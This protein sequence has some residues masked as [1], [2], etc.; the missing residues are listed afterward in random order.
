MKKTLFLLHVLALSTLATA[1][2]ETTTGATIIDSPYSYT[3][4]GTSIELGSNFYTNTG[5]MAITFELS[6]ATFNDIVEAGGTFFTLSLKPDNGTSAKTISVTYGQGFFMISGMG[7]T[8]FDSYVPYI[9]V[10]VPLVFQYNSETKTFSFSY[11]HEYDSTENPYD[12]TNVLVG[13]PMGANNP[14]ESE[15]FSAG[16]L[17]ITLP[18]GTATDIL[19]WDGLV[20]AEDIHNYREFG[21]IEIDTSMQGGASLDDIVNPDS[22]SSTGNSDYMP[23]VTLTL[24]AAAV[25]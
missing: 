22:S 17:T 9:P 14:F 18:K 7:S 2:A 23:G 8:S 12:L 1:E 4:S 13:G 25:S 5:S 3:G 24:E 19:T 21:S 15:N 11:Y 20:T 10:E 16:A 6:G